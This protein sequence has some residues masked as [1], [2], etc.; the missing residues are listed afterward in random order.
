[1]TTTEATL[2]KPVCFKCGAETERGG[3]LGHTL[4]AHP[5]AAEVPEAPKAKRYCRKVACVEEALGYEFVYHLAG[6]CCR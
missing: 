3:L 2:T 6:T 1:M 4:T 5:K